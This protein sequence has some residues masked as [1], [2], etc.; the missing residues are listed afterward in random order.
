MNATTAA[1][2]KIGQYEP[3]NLPS[4]FT[5]TL[6]FIHRITRTLNDIRYHIIGFR[7]VSTDTSNIFKSLDLYW[8]YRVSSLFIDFVGYPYLQNYIPMNI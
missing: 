1:M 2:M 3:K 4:G 5:P 6:H 8:N 7:N